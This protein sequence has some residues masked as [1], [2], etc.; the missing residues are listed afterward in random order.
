MD[1]EKEPYIPFLSRRFISPKGDFYAGT[2]GYLYAN[3]GSSTL[4][5]HTNLQKLTQNGT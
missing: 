1:E 3:E 5:P 4:L 2:T